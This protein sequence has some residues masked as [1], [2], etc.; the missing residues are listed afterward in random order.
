MVINPLSVTGVLFLHFHQYD[1][2]KAAETSCN[3]QIYT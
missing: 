3:L 1:D 2:F